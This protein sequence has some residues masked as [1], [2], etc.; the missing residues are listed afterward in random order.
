MTFIDDV[1]PLENMSEIE[2][3]SD[4]IPARLDINRLRGDMSRR[5][6]ELVD[7]INASVHPD[8]ESVI[9]NPH[10]IEIESGVKVEAEYALEELAKLPKKKKARQSGS[11][12]W[13]C[14]DAR[15]THED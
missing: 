1:H 7:T 14:S 13:F 5:I 3:A 9:L 12:S 6:I 2:Q 4:T 10:Y 15:L 11:G 8:V